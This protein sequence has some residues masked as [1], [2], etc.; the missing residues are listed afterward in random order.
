MISLK[1]V[2]FYVL[3]V[4]TDGDLHGYGLVKEIERR[5]E[6][7]MRLEPGNLYR[8]VRRLVDAGLVEPATRR[9]VPSPSARPSAQA[10]RRRYYRI[11]AR[12][13]D[14]LRSDVE[15]M[16]SLVAAAE[17]GLTAAEGTS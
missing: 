1:P 16:R 11:T 12:G 17:S 13:R 8:Y 15:R 5:S 4:L 14:V 10:E 9:P 7:G 3:L 6:G 2:D